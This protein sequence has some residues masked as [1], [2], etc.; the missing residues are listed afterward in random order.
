MKIAALLLL[1]TGTAWTQSWLTDLLPAE[2]RVVIGINVR[3]IIDSAVLPNFGSDPKTV[4]ALLLAQKELN[5]LDPLKDVDSVLVVITGDGPTPPGLAI[6]RGHFDAEK[7]G[8]AL[9]NNKDPKNM[10]VVLDPTT[11]LAGDV[12]TVR[13]AMDGRGKPHKTDAALV[14]KIDSLSARFDVWGL[15]D[16][17]KGFAAANG[18]SGGLEAVDHFEFGAAFRKGLTIEAQAHVRSTQDSKKMT[19][20]LAMLEKMFSVRQTSSNGGKFSLTSQNGTFKLSLVL[21]EEELKKAIVMQKTSIAKALTPA[22]KPTRPEDV[23]I[24]S[25]PNGDTFQVI[26][27]GGK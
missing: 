6:V 20:S 17:P 14:A 1:W 18:A 7:L 26:L 22:P 24:V 9:A 4:S 23:K 13:A 3:A 2:H 15:G 21:T 11:L 8:P 16:V 25:R 12:P 27:P 10:A 5:G 19:E